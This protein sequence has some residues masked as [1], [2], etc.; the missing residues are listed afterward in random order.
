VP[1]NQ[2]AR[3]P[4]GRDEQN[5]V[6]FPLGVLSER[7]T[8]RS[9][10]TRYRFDGDG[11]RY[12]ELECHPDYGVPT[13]LDKEVY[14]ALMEAIYLQRY[15]E[16][17][18]SQALYR[19]LDARGNDGK[20]LFQIGITKLCV[21]RL[22]MTPA[23]PSQFRQRLDPAHK[24]LLA[25]GFL[26]R[27]EYEKGAAETLVRYY[28]PSRKSAAAKLDRTPA[29]PQPAAKPND[30]AR[31]VA[32]WKAL[33]P[34]ERSSLLEELLPQIEQENKMVAAFARR[35]PDG[36]VIATAL[37]PLLLARGLGI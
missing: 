10:Q 27:V 14:V 18:V 37:A 21:H 30:Q 22:G 16:L 28:F 24:E 26:A 4:S 36:E 17:P 20:V 23:Y 6:P 5:L 31:V 1:H 25:R 29:R 7:P 2:R 35:R 9:S 12:W 19:L 33:S 32:W 3:R 15:L 34:E 8:Q 13:P 11:D